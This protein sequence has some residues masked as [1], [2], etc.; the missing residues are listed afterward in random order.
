MET[1]T[2]ELTQPLTGWKVRYGETDVDYYS[3]NLVLVRDFT[4]KMYFWPIDIGELRKDPNLVQ[5]YGW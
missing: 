3:E 4:P 2:T 5:N 1:A